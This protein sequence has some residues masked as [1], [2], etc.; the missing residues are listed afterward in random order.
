MPYVQLSNCDIGAFLS[1]KSNI[2]TTAGELS[3]G[4]GQ[5]FNVY[6]GGPNSI[7]LDPAAGFNG[8]PGSTTPETA[9]QFMFITTHAVWM[10]NNVDDGWYGWLND[11]LDVPQDKTYLGVVNPVI[12]LVYASVDLQDAGD[13]T[14]GLRITSANEC[15]LSLCDVES[16]VATKNCTDSTFTSQTTFG[17]ISYST[18]DQNKTLYHLSNPARGLTGNNYSQ[19]RT[20]TSCWSPDPASREDQIAICGNASLPNKVFCP[21]GLLNSC[22]LKD[23]PSSILTFASTLSSRLTEFSETFYCHSSNDNHLLE[24]VDCY[25]APDVIQGSY[26]G[27]TN[28]TSP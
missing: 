3:Y 2:S 10:L 18:T 19:T 22:D 20:W 1:N 7:Y 13:F 6:Q 23:A 11:S 16:D 25:E 27:F 9:E 24:G 17:V 4:H 26:L 12:T 14:R 5:P 8:G 15:V 28:Y 21:N